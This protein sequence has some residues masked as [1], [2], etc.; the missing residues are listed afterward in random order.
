MS[1]NDATTTGTN[2][3]TTTGDA[4]QRDPK[5]SWRYETLQVHAGQEPAQSLVER[6]CRRRCRC[7]ARQGGGASRQ[8]VGRLGRLAEAAF[9][10]HDRC[11]RAG[12]QRGL[13]RHRTRARPLR[14]AEVKL[15]QIALLK[16]AASV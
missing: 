12:R 6:R 10:R 15:K 2:T 3:G 1:S 16:C 14:E 4:A 9:H 7:L 13:S 11:A 8:L 5:A